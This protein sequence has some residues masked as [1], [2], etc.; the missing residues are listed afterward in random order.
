MPLSNFAKVTINSMK[1]AVL[2]DTKLRNFVLEA[3]KHQKIS[4]KKRDFYH[5][6]GLSVPSFLIFSVTNRCNLSCK[7][8]YHTAHKRKK[9]KEISSSKIA[10]IIKE[11]DELGISA[12]VIAGGE[13]LIRPEILEVTKNLPNVIF[14]MFTN[15]T[16]LNEKIINKL[17]SQ[18]NVVT[19]F[20]IEGYQHET[21]ER[22]GI[23][24]YEILENKMKIFQEEK[25]LFGVSLTVTKNN[26]QTL[27][28]EKF[29]KKYL[30][31]G[32][33]VFFFGEYIPIQKGTKEWILNNK[34][35]E[36]LKN[37]VAQYRK[38]FPAVFLTTSDE[39]QFGGCQ[40]AG[41]GFIH[42]N[43]QGDV[44][45][46]PMSPFSDVNLQTMSLKKALE[47]KLLAEIRKNP[48]ALEEAEGGC[49]LWDKKDWIK[50]LLTDNK[51]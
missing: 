41:R 51:V 19:I 4:A 27:V 15:G 30:D 42:I 38:K 2:F 10:S 3:I 47:S 6:K 50:S 35:R 24:I 5:K 34:Q 22:R 39:D 1:K 21:D 9:E 20:S 44:E 46:C 13:P 40:A 32:S 7:G 12:V 43:P 16:I 48:M 49:A 8:C 18:P 26:F 45:P 23:G 25:L 36:I 11:A 17:K 14:L 33:R 37:H 31:L 28:D 29:I